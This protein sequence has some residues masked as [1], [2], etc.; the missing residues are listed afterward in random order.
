MNFFLSFNRNILD[1]RIKSEHFLNTFYLYSMCHIVLVYMLV[2]PIIDRCDS[3]Y[4]YSNHTQL[5]TQSYTTVYDLSRWINRNLNL[6]E[7][8]L[9]TQT[10]RQTYKDKT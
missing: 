8:Y 9:N 2:F 5:C 1:F 6:I 10:E 4:I 3:L 7:L